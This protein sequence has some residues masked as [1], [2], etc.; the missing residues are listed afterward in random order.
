MTKA[1]GDASGHDHGGGGAAMLT[2]T[3]LWADVV[4]VLFVGASAGAALW[5]VVALVRP[6]RRHLHDLCYAGMAA[7]MGLMLVVMNA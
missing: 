1:E 3:P 4:N 7:G 6:R 2:S 5:W